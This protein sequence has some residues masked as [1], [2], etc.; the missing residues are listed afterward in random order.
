MSSPEELFTEMGHELHSLEADRTFLEG[1]VVRHQEKFEHVVQKLRWSEDGKSQA[2]KEI[3]QLRK[4]LDAE[5][6]G[7]GRPACVC[8]CRGGDRQ[9]RAEVRPGSTSARGSGV[10]R[11]CGPPTGRGRAAM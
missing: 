2:Q 5:R 10:G 7:S 8:K 11:G 3:E 9:Q 1:E 6:A 4:E